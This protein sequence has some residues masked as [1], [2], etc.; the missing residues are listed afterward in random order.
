MISTQIFISAIVLLSVVQ[1]ITC[2]DKTG[3]T[4]GATKP[5]KDAYIDI[6]KSES[7]SYITSLDKTGTTVGAS[8]ATKPDKDAYIGINKSESPSEEEAMMNEE[9]PEKK[10]MASRFCNLITKPISVFW[11]PIQGAL[12]SSLKT[13]VKLF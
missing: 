2:L 11:E 12:S 8:T 1:Y 3:T 7:P 10:S 9:I 6:N 4:V 5:N 13:A